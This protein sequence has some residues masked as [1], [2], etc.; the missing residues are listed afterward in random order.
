MLS[1]VNAKVFGRGIQESEVTEIRMAQPPWR[2]H[3]IAE[4]G[5]S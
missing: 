5:V 3:R 4:A 1:S 2:P